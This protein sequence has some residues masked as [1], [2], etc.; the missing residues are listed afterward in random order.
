MD[1]FA[2]TIRG[3][4]QENLRRMLVRSG[5]AAISVVFLEILAL[6]PLL[7]EAVAPDS[8]TNVTANGACSKVVLSWVKS[9]GTVYCNIYCNDGES[10]WDTPK[11]MYV[12]PDESFTDNDVTVGQTYWYRISAGNSA[13]EESE[14]SLPAVSVTVYEGSSIRQTTP[15]WD[16]DEPLKEEGGAILIK[17]S[18][19]D[20]VQDGITYYSISRANSPD[21][22]S[23]KYQYIYE[24]DY[25][26]TDIEPDTVYYY[27]LSATSPNNESY[28]TDAESITTSLGAGYLPKPPQNLTAATGNFQ[29]KLDP[30]GIYTF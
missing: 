21:A 11:Y 4:R 24:T 26:D 29:V 28:A 3:S 7:V 19:A 27:R 10:G 17:W 12:D 15:T 14:P 9:V 25:T 5:K 18:A 30:I 1:R 13:Y 16:T 20:D 8:P 6:F 23:V 2:N 22:W